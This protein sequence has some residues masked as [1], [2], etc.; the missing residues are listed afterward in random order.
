MKKS[1]A[2]VLVVLFLTSCVSVLRK[3]LMDTGIRN[4]SFADIIRNP[5]GNKGRLFVLGGIIVNTTVTRAGSR[6]EAL[7]A[8]VDSSG[9]LQ[10][11]RGPTVRF[12]AVLPGNLGFLDP[13]IYKQN[14]Q[15]TLAAFFTHNELGKIDD[16]EYLFP[17]FQIEQIYLWE[18][19]PAVAYAPYPWTPY[20]WSPYPY[21][22]PHWPYRPWGYYHPYW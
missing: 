20:P 11:F 14:R 21:W 22:G 10:D 8:P 13:L 7:Y 6:I 15:I 12:R 18:E 9:Y 5:E 2:L 17:V 16:M 3:D 4:F 19:R 1:L